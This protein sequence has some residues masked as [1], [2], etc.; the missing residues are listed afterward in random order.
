MKAETLRMAIKEA[1]RF[2]AVAKEVGVIYD[3]YDNGESYIHVGDCTKESAA[4]KRASMDLSRVLSDLRQ[5]R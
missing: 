1:E 4:C 5:G 2:A 3:R